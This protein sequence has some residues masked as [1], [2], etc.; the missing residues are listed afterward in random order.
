MRLECAERP[1]LGRIPFPPS[2]I[3]RS[4]PDVGGRYWTEKGGGIKFQ[5]PLPKP[6]RSLERY[7][8]KLLLV[9]GS[10]Q[11]VTA[12]PRFTVALYFLGLGVRRR[13]DRG[14]V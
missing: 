11:M 8:G 5:E 3:Y 7:V 10:R 9:E 14:R 12:Q 13:L 2:K 6:N 4:A 1:G